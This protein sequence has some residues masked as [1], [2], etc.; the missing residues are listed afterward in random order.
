MR[1][2]NITLNP[3]AGFLNKTVSFTDGVN[4]V[5]GKNEAGK[6][7]L[8]KALKMILFDSTF[9]TP[10]AGKKLLKDVLPVDGGDTVGVSLEFE[11]EGDTYHLNKKWGAAPSCSFHKANQAPITEPGRVQSELNNILKQNRLVWESVM[12]ASQA[13]IP[14][15]HTFLEKNKD[16]STDLDRILQNAV[17]NNLGVA[18]EKITE[19]IEVQLNSLCTHWNLDLDKPLIGNTGKGS[20]DNRYNNPGEILSLDYQLFDK[21]IKLETRKKYDERLDEK[22]RNLE[23]KNAQL[24][25]VSQ[26]VEKYKNKI[27]GYRKLSSLN[28]QKSRLENEN[29]TL[30]TDCNA[31]SSASSQLE[32]LRQNGA[33]DRVEKESIDKELQVANTKNNSGFIVS[34][35]NNIDQLLQQKDR[36]MAVQQGYKCIRRE[37]K[38]QLDNM[39]AE[40]NGEKV[41][42]DAL[43]NMQGFHV[44]LTASNNIS[45]DL[46]QQKTGR[47]TIDLF[48]ASPYEF[49]ANGSFELKSHEL[50]LKVIASID[51]LRNTEIR[52]A[53]LESALQRIVAEY[54]AESVEALLESDKQW[55]K[56]E[57]EII[58]LDRDIKGKLGAE[59][60]ETLAARVQALNELPE[61][62]SVETLTKLQGEAA[63]RLAE[64]IA[65]YRAKES[66]QKN[67]QEKYTTLDRLKSIQLDKL[68]E[69]RQVNDAIS[70][71]AEMPEDNKTSEELIALYDQKN[72]GGIDCPL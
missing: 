31:W 72:F 42:F 40:L 60:F 2:I 63:E 59:T 22:V 55:Q 54:D 6:S 36:I 33:R 41:R 15:T 17:M 5:F 23:S 38:L 61:C 68:I 32:L 28:Y 52:I 1:L 37:D 7:T 51:N 69:L 50:H 48:T 18:P 66:I 11:H 4:V 67:Y 47:Q 10:A 24:E 71:L 49:D 19:E 44:E 70:Q 27:D 35:K 58:N 14:D 57:T 12:I 29:N 8:I 62:R 26:F 64:S 9:Q 20:Y 53:E 56:C 21:R 3:F 16:V 46:T 25:E 43:S 30:K 34:N 45:I 39:Q 13:Q 65:A